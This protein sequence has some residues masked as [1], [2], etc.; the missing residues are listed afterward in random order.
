MKW[1]AISGSWRKTNDQV[2][3]DVVG[4]VRKIISTGDG[5]VCGGA[6]GVDYIATNESIKLDSSC[7]KIR[8]FLPVKLD[9]FTKHYLKR[10]NQGVITHQQAKDLVSQLNHL[11]EINPKSIIE[12]KDNLVVNKDTYYSR[13]SE[14]VAVADKLI[15]FQ[16]NDSQGTQDT[17]NKA[18]QKGIPVK[19]F[20]YLL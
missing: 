8:I 11:K 19:V 6:L 2:K 1:I 15:A 16:V 13:N 4:T 10:S 5:I 9:V 7:Q 17:I 20:K 18:K 3:K 14:I 12:N